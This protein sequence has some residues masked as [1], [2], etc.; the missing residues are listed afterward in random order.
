M[1]SFKLFGRLLA[2]VAAVLAS[3]SVYAQELPVEYQSV[4]TTLGKTGD[5]KDGV[6]KVN[7]PRNG[8]RVTI[9]SVA[10]IFIGRRC[11]RSSSEDRRSRRAHLHS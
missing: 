9:G 6:L 2:F 7:I 8:L 3:G 1:V 10:S 11:H 5:V 4:V